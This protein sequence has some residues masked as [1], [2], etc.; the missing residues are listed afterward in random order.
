MK[1]VSKK[2]IGGAQACSTYLPFAL[3]KVKLLDKSR[4]NKAVTTKGYSFSN[5][6]EIKCTATRKLLSVQIQAALG[7][8]VFIGTNN[9]VASVE[10][11][12]TDK[13]THVHYS[14]ENVFSQLPNY[15]EHMPDL[16]HTGDTIP[17][18]KY[19]WRNDFYTVFAGIGTRYSTPVYNNTVVEYYFGITHFDDTLPSVMNKSYSLLVKGIEGSE[20]VACAV[21]EGYAVG[22]DKRGVLKYW[23]LS[24]NTD[25]QTLQLDLPSWAGGTIVLETIL[26]SG[27][28]FSGQHAWLGGTSGIEW[29]FNST[30]DKL[31]GIIREIVNFGWGDPYS[32]TAPILGVDDGITSKHTWRTRPVGLIINL[33]PSVDAT[34]NISFSP[35][36]INTGYNYGLMAIDWYSLDNPHES[37]P[38]L[39]KPENDILSYSFMTSYK[40]GSEIRY[41]MTLITERFQLADPTIYHDSFNISIYD[42]SGDTWPSGLFNYPLPWYGRITGID[43][44][45]HTYSYI[46]NG[47]ESFP[48]TFKGDDIS[49]ARGFDDYT[50]KHQIGDIGVSTAM[51]DFDNG[52]QKYAGAEIVGR[53]G[54]TES[55]MNRTNQLS[56]YAHGS[57]CAAVDKGIKKFAYMSA[58]HA[59]TG[60]Y[61]DIIQIDDIAYTHQE[62]FESLGFTQTT[63]AEGEIE[64]VYHVLGV[65]T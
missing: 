8:L 43:L 9:D 58:T 15:V 51:F 6:V 17:G 27:V 18:T 42:N 3:N 46:G 50:Y 63:N 44:R 26:G 13:F 36:T 20:C 59:N 49:F 53:V 38:E 24:D 2:Y 39:K 21:H 60:E 32:G 55:S 52:V 28:F 10:T 64:A 30:G 11:F 62:V 16:A 31:V 48:S 12:T 37:D 23:P 33:N 35:D 1:P 19:D 41:R 25:I 7:G 65:F 54:E 61:Y 40:V 34:G 29:K 56:S 5:G 45:Y 57:S 22:V 4:K 14:R 47:H